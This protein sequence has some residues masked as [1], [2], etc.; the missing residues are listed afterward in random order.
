MKD[1]KLK[2]GKK[3]KALRQNLD[4][5]LDDVAKASEFSVSLLSKIEN[6]K[7]F[8]SA[9]TLIKI[10]KALNSNIQSILEE[11]SPTSVVFT[12][13][14]KAENRFI[15]T[16]KGFQIFPYATDHK[17]NRIQAFLYKATKG[18]VRN[19]SDSHEGQEFIF[20]IDG[21]L[22]VRIKDAKYTLNPGDTI[23][24]NS[25]EDHQCIPISDE[26]NYLIFFA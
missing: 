19:H 10:A 4:F 14:E 3:I 8:P 16:E 12:P 9:G 11:D 26:A 1:K 18:H 22:C 17:E 13:K 2:I 5:T 15:R 21:T 25:H 7:V 23:Y 20:L 24:F 6:D